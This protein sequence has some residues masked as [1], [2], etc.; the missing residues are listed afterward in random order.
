MS[1]LPSSISPVSRLKAQ[2]GSSTKLQLSAIRSSEKEFCFLKGLKTNLIELDEFLENEKDNRK[3]S[4][5]SQ[6]KVS[7]A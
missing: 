1:S 4:F 7:W 6:E 2:N 3:V 5:M